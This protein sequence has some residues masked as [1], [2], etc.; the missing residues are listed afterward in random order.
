MGWDALTPADAAR[1]RL[2]RRQKIAETAMMMMIAIPP[3][4]PHTIATAFKLLPF[5]RGVE[6]GVAEEDALAGEGVYTPEA[7]KI[8]PGPYSGLPI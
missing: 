1:E 5:G 7:P 6:D 4:T 2:H 8:A 3:T